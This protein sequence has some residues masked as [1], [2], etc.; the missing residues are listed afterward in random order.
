MQTKIPMAMSYQRFWSDSFK[1]SEKDKIFFSSGFKITPYLSIG[2]TAEKEPKKSPWNGDLGS[3]LKLGNQTSLALFV[4]H[5]LK[6]KKENK[7]I[8]SMAVY[9]NWKSFFSTQLDI[10]RTAHKKWI[11][12]GG[13][14]SFFQQFLSIRLGGIWLQESQKAFISG[15]VVFHSPRMSIEYSVEKDEE[16]SYQQAVILAIR[17]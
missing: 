2:F 4:N 5:V 15:G 17:I 1:K 14:E 3:V 6:R 16:H 13:L 9:Q 12:R 8:L 7:R 11:F 10:S